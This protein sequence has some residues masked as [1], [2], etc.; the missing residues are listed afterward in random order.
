MRKP[1]SSD[2]LAQQLKQRSEDDE[3]WARESV[4]IVARPS[5]TSVLSLRLPTGE[6]HALLSAARGSGES[7]SE[8]VRGAI[9]LRR[10]LQPVAPTVNVTY[11]YPG[12]PGTVEYQSWDWYTSSTPQ[13]E[14]N[15]ASTR[16]A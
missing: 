4:Q 12:M 7:V 2:E 5:R 13:A 9:T 15:A 8:Y 3:L 6:F 16:T 1:K 10:M 14:P 11:S